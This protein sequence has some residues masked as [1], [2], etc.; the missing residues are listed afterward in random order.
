MASRRNSITILLAAALLLLL[1]AGLVRLFTLRFQ[2]GTLYPPASSLRCDPQGCR[3]LF[4]ALKRLPNLTVKRTF[5]PTDLTGNP[6]TTVLLLGA[7]RNPL[8][9]LENCDIESFMLAGGRL[10]LACHSEKPSYINDNV[11]ETPPDADPENTDE[12]EDEEKTQAE[13][14]LSSRKWGVIPARFSR[15]ELKE[16]DPQ[17]TAIPETPDSPPL[18]W[19]SAIWFNELSSDWTVLYR[20]L[21]KPVIIERTWG[22][23]S[24]LLIADSF[25]FSNEAMVTDR[26]TQALTQL[27]GPTD[28]LLFD[29]SHLGIHSDESI[30]M[31]I[32]RYRLQGVLAALA[33]LA[34]LFLWQ[35]STGLI[36][37]QEQ[38]SRPGL[39]PDA[40]IG[41]MQGMINLLKRH[42][43]RKNL[44]E[45]LLSEWRASFQNDPS[46]Q[47]KK[48]QLKTELD[49][50]DDRTHPVELYNRI[51]KALNERKHA[52]ITHS[53]SSR[54][55]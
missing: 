34:A 12:N 19:K 28:L 49:R 31:L 25:L 55:S 38:H 14:I 47:R 46:M 33:I 36:P 26:P 30:M 52:W 37:K 32:H 13:I 40:S 3:I 10:L 39:D 45:T 18:P 53:N 1:G 29:E 11:E 17:Q 42:I 9:E 44:T 5:R 51:T 20:Y 27:I 35:Q 54:N 22:K 16:T 41:S 7:D 8:N 4:D 6:G 15:S 48:D 23:G 21:D 50:A 24:L 2:D 43:P